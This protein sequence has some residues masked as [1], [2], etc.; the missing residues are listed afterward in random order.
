MATAAAAAA[1]RSSCRSHTHLHLTVDAATLSMFSNATE[2]VD[3]E[4]AQPARWTGSVG[5]TGPASSGFGRTNLVFWEGGT[6]I[7]IGSAHLFRQSLI[8]CYLLSV[9]VMKSDQSNLPQK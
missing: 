9:T 1:G 8:G 4:R 7:T 2:H 6:N 3:L 5:S